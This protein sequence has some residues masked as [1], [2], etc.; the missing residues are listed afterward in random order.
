MV[1]KFPVLV[2]FALILAVLLSA[3]ASPEGPAETPEAPG[4]IPETGAL[5]EGMPS[6]MSP[7]LG[8]DV[9]DNEG[10]SRGHVVDIILSPFGLPEYL[11]VST[12]EQYIPTPF[13]AFLWDEEQERVVF[14]LDRQLLEGAPSFPSLEDF[15]ALDIAGWDQHIDAYWVEHVDVTGAAEQTPVQWDVPSRVNLA[16]ESPVIDFEGEEIAQVVEILYNQAEER[17]FVVIQR[18]GQFFPVPWEEFNW[19]QVNARLIY[20]YEVE[21]LENAPQYDSLDDLNT[22]QSGWDEEIS[23]Y[24]RMP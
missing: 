12:E 13:T 11:I 10:Q 4:V 1:K 6:R 15:P 8:A 14:G 3:C 18:D 22:T 16:L 20:L 23:A 21:R 7:I 24:W 17:G 19:D 9:V 5:E 2:L